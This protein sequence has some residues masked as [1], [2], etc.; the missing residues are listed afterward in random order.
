MLPDGAGWLM[1]QFGGDSQDDADGQAH[2]LIDSLSGTEHEPSHSFF[3]DP[4]RQQELW[5]VRESGLGATAH[6]PGQPDTWPGWEDAAV[7]PDR[8]GDYLRDLQALYQEFGYDQ[9]SIY[10][11]FGQGCVHSGSRS[12]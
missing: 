6:L 11:H 12:T 8:L 2:A 5:E 10:G 9:A 4:Q 3:D 7:G 1:V